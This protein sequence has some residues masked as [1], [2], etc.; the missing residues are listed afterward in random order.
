MGALFEDAMLALGSV[1]FFLFDLGLPLL[2]V[3]TGV[4]HDV[5]QP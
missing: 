4:A 5:R 1:L 3:L 2:T